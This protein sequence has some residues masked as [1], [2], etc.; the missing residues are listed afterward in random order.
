MPVA[1]LEKQ[2][3][4]GNI[5]STDSSENVVP[6]ETSPRPIHGWKW[7]IAYASM[8]STTFLFALDNTIVRFHF[9][10]VVGT[11]VD[12]NNAGRRYSTRHSRPVW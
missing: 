12:R 8:I 9:P 10:H 11:Y 3:S 4:N 6:K 7:A 5:A 1:D 2:G